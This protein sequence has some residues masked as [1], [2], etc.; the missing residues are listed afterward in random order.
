MNQHED[1][2]TGQVDAKVLDLRKKCTYLVKEIEEVKNDYN[3][4]TED[5]G[6]SHSHKNLTS[7]TDQDD[8]EQ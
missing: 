7:S 2:C 4:M 6:R 3:M 1:L 8:E 5:D